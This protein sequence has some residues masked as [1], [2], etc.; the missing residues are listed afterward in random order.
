MV[1]LTIGVILTSDQ[2]R[3]VEAVNLGPIKVFMCRKKCKTD[4]TKCVRDSI[5][6][7]F[8]PSYV[9]FRRSLC[10]D[11]MAFCAK[12]CGDLQPPPEKFFDS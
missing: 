11:V 1:V 7:D 9:K 12:T 8:C 6:G 10:K 4:Y 5:T 3:G 2:N